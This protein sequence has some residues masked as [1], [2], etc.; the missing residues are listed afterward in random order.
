[1]EGIQLRMRNKGK[2]LS[3]SG[4]YPNASERYKQNNNHSAMQ[5]K[6]MSRETMSK[7]SNI[8]GHSSLYK[9]EFRFGFKHTVLRRVS[10][11]YRGAREKNF[12]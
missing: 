11:R 1:M 5:K 6:N 8:A 10:D 2:R 12:D 4:T 9:P 3:G 7:G